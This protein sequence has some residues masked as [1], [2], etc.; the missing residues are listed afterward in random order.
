MSSSSVT[1]DIKLI[2]AVENETCLYDPSLK[3]Y[4][5]ANKR[6]YAWERISEIVEGLFFIYLKKSIIFFCYPYK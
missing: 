4:R 6:N 3:D 5:D 1:F 2:K